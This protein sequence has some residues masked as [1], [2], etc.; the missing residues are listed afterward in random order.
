MPTNHVT[1]RGVAVVAIGG[2]ALVLDDSHKTVPDQFLAAKRA[3]KNVAD[4]GGR[5]GGCVDTW[6][7]AAGRLHSKEI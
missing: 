5:M 2:N 3:M 1:T 6:K 7:R 4:C